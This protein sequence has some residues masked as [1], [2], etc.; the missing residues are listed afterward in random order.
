MRKMAALSEEGRYD[1][2]CG[3]GTQDNTTVLHVK[4]TETAVR[5][6]ENYQN[7][8]VRKARGRQG[9]PPGY[10]PYGLLLGL[11]DVC[12]WR[13]VTEAM[14]PLLCP[15]LDEGVIVRARESHF[16]ALSELQ[17]YEPTRTGNPPPLIV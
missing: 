9:I 8:K 10:S 17:R 16:W 13:N 11:P 3:R 6:L 7:T 2:S 4:L 5:A 1:L 12:V 15:P 14:S